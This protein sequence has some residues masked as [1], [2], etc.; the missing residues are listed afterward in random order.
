MRFD[1]VQVVIWG[2]SLSRSEFVCCSLSCCGVIGRAISVQ[3]FVQTRAAIVV[4]SFRQYI[5][6]GRADLSN[7]PERGN[8]NAFS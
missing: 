6:S 8:T 4:A 7:H 1:A 5:L 2:R 3:R